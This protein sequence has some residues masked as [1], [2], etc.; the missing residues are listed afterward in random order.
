MLTD[1]HLDLTSL[2]I[3]NNLMTLPA[4]HEIKVQN[5]PRDEELGDLGSKSLGHVLG[6][7]VGDALQGQVDMD[8]KRK[9]ATI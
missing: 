4:P 3:G 1:L 7:D 2:P 8:W 5:L 6:A 9:E